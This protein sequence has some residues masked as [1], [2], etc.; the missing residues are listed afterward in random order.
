MYLY[1]SSSIEHKHDILSTLFS[2][3]VSTLSEE[4]LYEDSP[5]LARMKLLEI[6]DGTN[7]F[8]RFQTLFQPQIFT[9]HFPLQ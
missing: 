7:R 8:C 6:L 9:S 4:Q 5:E 2:S 1:G 3:S